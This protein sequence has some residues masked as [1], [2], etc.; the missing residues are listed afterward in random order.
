MTTGDDARPFRS[1]F[2]CCAP[3]DFPFCFV[4]PGD[5]HSPE[6]SDREEQEEIDDDAAFERELLEAGIGTYPPEHEL[7]FERESGIEE[8]L[9]SWGGIDGNDDEESGDVLLPEE[10]RRVTERLERLEDPSPREI[11]QALLARGYRGQD[12]A[13]R[14]GSV[15][16]YRHLQRLRREFLDNLPAEEL[17]LR[18]NYL[19][20][21]ATGSGK[22]FLVELLFRD[23][24]GVPTIVADVTRFSETG[25]IGDDVLMLLSEL[26]EAAGQ[27][28]GWASCGVICLDEF[29]KLAASRS[30]ARF[31][32]EGTTKD[33]SGFGVQRGL[34]NLLS[35]SSSPFPTDFGYSALGQRLTLPLRNLMFIAC[36]AFSGLKEASDLAS[37]S[38]AI[39]FHSTAT[40]EAKDALVARIGSEL[41]ENTRA[42]A[43]YGI[44]PELLGRFSRLVPFQPLGPEVLRTILED[45]VLSAYRRE[46][47]SEGVDLEIDSDVIGHVTEAAMRRETGA[48]GLR[49]SLVPHLEEAAFR[50]FGSPDGARVRIS[51]TNGEISMETESAEA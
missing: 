35:G 6:D 14:A 27:D 31:A 8:R 24:L 13:R 28:R 19:F 2:P 4:M 26:Y 1:T 12:Y 51:L 29:D 32:G 22:T 45:T 39:G 40:P 16:A 48:R 46:F 44:L 41:L 10:R 47:A 43:H 25:Y 17:S 11:E 42:F 15:L 37:G 21:G 20:V 23:I 34:L 18:E 38:R 7:F 30:A 49:A 5:E 33:V 50:T 36:G 3:I 9:D